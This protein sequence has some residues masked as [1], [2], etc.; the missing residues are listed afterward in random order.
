[1][2]IKAL[3]SLLIIIVLIYISL[4]LLVIFSKLDDQ[5]KTPAYILITCAA[6]LSLWIYGYGAINYLLIHF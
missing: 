5:Y 3:I 6:I 2:I 4:Y 1:M